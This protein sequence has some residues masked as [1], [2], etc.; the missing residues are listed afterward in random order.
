MEV[1]Y[2]V[3]VKAVKFSAQRLTRNR[4]GLFVVSIFFFNFILFAKSECDGDV[5]S[6]VK[7]MGGR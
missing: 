6:K 5:V 7:D 3:G 1:K 2:R 4:S